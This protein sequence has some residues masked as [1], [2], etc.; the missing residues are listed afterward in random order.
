MV[1]RMRSTRSKGGARRGGHVK[2]TSPTLV[3]EDGKLRPPHKM[4]RDNPVYRGRVDPLLSSRKDRNDK[5]A[6]SRVETKQEDQ[7]EVKKTKEEVKL[8]PAAAKEVS[9]KVSKD[10][11]KN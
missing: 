6:A 3:T 9:P 8:P 7:E 5:R 2:M 4:T 11:G 1:V 10:S